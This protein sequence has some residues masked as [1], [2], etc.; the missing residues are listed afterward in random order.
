MNKKTYDIYIEFTETRRVTVEAHTREEALGAVIDGGTEQGD[1]VCQ[2]SW[3]IYEMHECDHRN[4]MAG[5][6]C[7][8]DDARLHM[9]SF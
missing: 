7:R 9:R 4:D 3:E 8:V 6:E 1:F 5:R 2:D